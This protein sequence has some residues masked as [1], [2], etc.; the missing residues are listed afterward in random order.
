MFLIITFFFLFIL[1]VGRVLYGITPHEIEWGETLVS[2]LGSNKMHSTNQILI[3]LRRE[4]DA[5]VF[6]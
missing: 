6:K 4:K 3:D 5:G 2:L 1:F